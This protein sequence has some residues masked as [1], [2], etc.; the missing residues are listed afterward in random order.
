ME[1]DRP[2]LIYEL[3]KKTFK[4]YNTKHIMQWIN[5][6]LYLVIHCL[7]VVGMYACKILKD[8]TDTKIF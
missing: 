1:N 3:F 5:L 7:T 2:R 6:V 4:M 8:I